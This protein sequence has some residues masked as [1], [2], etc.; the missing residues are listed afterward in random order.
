[1]GALGRQGPA[2][3]EM[4]QQYFFGELS[5]ILGELQ[6]VATDDAAERAIARLRHEAEMGPLAA[7][8]SVAARA[9]ELTEGWCWDSLSR[10]DSATF[11][12]QTALCAG[13]WE[14]AVCA[15]LLEDR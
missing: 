10:G 11:A 12:R 6:A 5:L 14:F 8:G 3:V 4:T 13:L 7:L 15:G 2:V 9:L 1:M